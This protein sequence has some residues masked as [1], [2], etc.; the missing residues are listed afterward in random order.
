MDWPSRSVWSRIAWAGV[1]LRL[2]RVRWHLDPRAPSRG[3]PVWWPQFE[4]AFWAHVAA[5]SRPSHA[6]PSSVRVARARFARSLRS[7]D[8]RP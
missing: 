7:Q 2:W 8:D 1:R 6:S 3:E 5:L 4:N